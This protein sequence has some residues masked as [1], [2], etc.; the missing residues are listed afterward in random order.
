MTDF[1]SFG[2]AC[3]ELL[4][5][6]EKK[7]MQTKICPKCRRELPL[8]NFTK[9]SNGEFYIYCKECKKDMIVRGDRFFLNV[10]KQGKSRSW[11]TFLAV[12]RRMG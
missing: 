10:K 7:K 3:N 2:E 5:S 4:Q 9:M 11:I 6:W 1:K 8:N 12:G